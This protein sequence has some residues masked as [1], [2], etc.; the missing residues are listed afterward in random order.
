MRAKPNACH[1][2]W[3]GTCGTC[4][5]RP[6]G[7]DPGRKPVCGGGHGARE[8]VD[9]HACLRQG[10][11]GCREVGSGS[12]PGAASAL[13][14]HPAVRH[15][16]RLGVEPRS[17]AVRDC[18]QV[19]TCSTG[20]CRETAKGRYSSVIGLNRTRAVR[21]FDAG[22][23]HMPSGATCI[24]MPAYLRSGHPGPLCG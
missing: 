15:D 4:H 7:H 17:R 19:Y 1:A 21:G 23:G 14:R 13:A 6:A 2:V 24:R 12:V 22:V 5:G 10:P 11:G 9:V 8:R 3:Y 16:H 18:D 20:L